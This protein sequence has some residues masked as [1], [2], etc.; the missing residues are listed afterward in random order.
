[1]HLHSTGIKVAWDKKKKNI[2]IYSLNV[3]CIF[4]TGQF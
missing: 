3:F 2:D 4:N 1:M